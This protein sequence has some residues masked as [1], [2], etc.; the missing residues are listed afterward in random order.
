M[1]FIGKLS[2]KVYF[3]GFFCYSWRLVLLLDTKSLYWYNISFYDWLWFS[4]SRVHYRQAHK[5]T[6]DF[7]LCAAIRAGLYYFCYT[8]FGI[9]FLVCVIFQ[10][11]SLFSYV[12]FSAS[13]KNPMC[14]NIKMYFGSKLYFSCVSSLSS[15]C[16]LML[17]LLY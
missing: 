8:C 4:P 7:D 3:E 5:F 6:L 15:S 9:S 16:Y 1:L 13:D 11:N 2:K 10:R 14:C 17:E 12:F